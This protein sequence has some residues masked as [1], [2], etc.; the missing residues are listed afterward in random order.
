MLV[1]TALPE[2]D[3]LSLTLNKSQERIPLIQ[4]YVPTGNLIIFQRWAAQNV[5]RQKQY[6]GRQVSLLNELMQSIPRCW[7]N[8]NVYYKL[9]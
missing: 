6:E 2:F 5:H 3:S 1:R 9:M 7:Y 4:H 8:L